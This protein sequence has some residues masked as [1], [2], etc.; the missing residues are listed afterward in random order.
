MIDIKS[1]VVILSL[2][3]VALL[4]VC[5]VLIFLYV[6]Q[7]K[8]IS[9]LADSINDFISN[10]TPID[11][12]VSDNEFS[13]LQNSVSDLANLIILEKSNT[14]KQIKKNTEFI[15]DVSHHLKTPLAALRLY[16]EMEL[17]ENPSEH[18]KTQLELIEKMENLVQNLLRL[19][20]IRSDAYIMKFEKASISEIANTLVG[21]F[22]PLFLQKSTQF[23]ATAF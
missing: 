8:N 20:K 7:N 12:S 2:C 15:S 19:E 4:S 6:H 9:K 10:R 14:Q 11:F 5:A 16:C 23:T 3:C 17:A 18:I 22:S 21:D 1:A 13:R